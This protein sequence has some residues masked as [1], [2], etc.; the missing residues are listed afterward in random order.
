VA[1]TL[2]L[3]SVTPNAAGKLFGAA[4]PVPLTTGTLTGFLAGD[5]V[6]ATYTRVAGEAVG[7][8]A[9]SATLSPAGVLGNYTITYNTATFTVTFGLGASSSFAVLGGAAAS[10]CTGVSTVNGNVGVDPTGTISGFPAPCVIAAPGDGVIHLNDAM[11]AAAQA[12]VTSASATLASMACQV[13]LTGQDLG[14]LIL[15]PGVYCFTSSAQLTGTLTLNGPANGIWIFQIGS[16]LTSAGGSTVALTGSA[17]AAN[18][19]WRVGSAAT[20]GATN[21]P[22]RGTIL[23]TAGISLGAGTSLTGRALSKA[24]VIMDTNVITL[25]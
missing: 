3:A 22:F 4:D 11:A 16:T 20:I 8:Y 19:F 1:A 2:K 12:D 14:G 17:S 6:T 13:D 21:A 23:A 10:S 24:A 18:V 9:I 15:T 7:T 5:G 25:P